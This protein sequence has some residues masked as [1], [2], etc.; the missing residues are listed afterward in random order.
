METKRYSSGTKW[1]E[2][3][4]YSRAIRKGNLIHVAGTTAVNDAGEIVGLGNMTEQTSFIFSK[5]EKALKA[6]GGNLE[7]VIRTRV[8]VVE[9][10]DWEAAAKVHGTVFR[11]IRP[12]ETLLM[13]SSLVNPD[14]LVEIE[15]EAIVDEH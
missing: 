3:F 13:I 8:Y 15:A 9:G 14:L 7:D 12:A 2:A 4:A 1:E 11:D 5:I 6:L 10:A